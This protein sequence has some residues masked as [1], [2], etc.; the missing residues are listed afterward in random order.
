MAQESRTK[1]DAWRKLETGTNEGRRGWYGMKE[2]GCEGK[3]RA[4]IERSDDEK[5]RQNTRRA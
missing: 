4:R 5:S 3:N 2:H 1:V